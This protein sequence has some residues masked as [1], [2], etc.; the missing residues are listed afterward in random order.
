MSAIRYPVGTPSRTQLP[1]V[2][3]VT[4][5]ASVSCALLC[6]WLL[7][8]ALGVSAVQ[9]SR[10]QEQLYGQLRQELALAT[11]KIGGNIDP[12]TPIALIE[13][14]AIHLRQVVVEGTSAGVLRAGPGHRRNT[15]LPGQPGT[16]VLYGH[17]AGFGAPFR[18]ITKLRSGDVITVTTGQGRFDF[19]VSGVRRAQDPLPVPP[20]QGGGRITLVTAEGSGWRGGWAPDHVVYVDAVMRGIAQAGPPGRPRS[21]DTAEFAMQGDPDAFIPLVLWLQ[22]LGLGAAAAT[23]ARLRWGG[24]QTWFIGVPVVLAGLWGVA[25]SMAQFLPNLG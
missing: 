19:D 15:P 7:A 10:T 9:Q 17:S 18:S 11:T 25:E 13:A 6:A 22:V 1:A 20:P 5:W 24:R 16:A 21:V 4:I 14:P 12:G 8:Y 3:S 23:A 2:A